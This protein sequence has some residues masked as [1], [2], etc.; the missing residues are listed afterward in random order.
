MALKIKDIQTPVANEMA[1]FEKRFRHS[2]KSNV[3]LLDKI[4]S[5]IV[6]R[7]G[8]QMRPM[9]VFLTASTVGQIQDSTYRGASLIELLH[10]A[11][12]VH[13][14]VVDESTY[15]RGFFSVNALW[16]NK[17]AVLV[18][19]F[20]LSRGM[21]LSIDNGDFDLLK[22]VSEAIREMSEGEILQ[23]EKA[24]KLDI[25]EEIYYEVIRQKTA[26]LI[27]SCCKVG[28]ASTGA[29]ADTVK[30]MGE[31][32]EKVGMAFQI[33]DDLFDYGTQE[34][35]KPLGIDIRE[36]KMTLPLIYALTQ[37]SWS[38]KRRIINIIKKHNENTKKV[39]EVI[40]FVIQKGGLEYAEGVMNRFHQEAVEILH[41]FPESAARQSLEQL[42]QFT[43]ERS[44]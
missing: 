7:K 25:T 26:S 30:A 3:M 33:K 24:K 17:I 42:V 29:D 40:Q 31:F 37:S 39:N 5:Y 14:D 4:M 41:T 8:K 44:K 20:L 15:R 11:T 38:E 19:D 35:G 13:D 10:T 32:G 21:L 34:I 22:I 12:L 27:T 36:K 9:F 28:A 23:M 1:E 43:I 2:M 18:G 6:K 16:K